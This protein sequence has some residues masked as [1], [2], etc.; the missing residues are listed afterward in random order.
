M[1]KSGWFIAMSLA[2]LFLVLIIVLLIVSVA[3]HNRGAKHV[4][5]LTEVHGVRSDEHHCPDRSQ[6]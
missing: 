6:S 3:K 5:Q 2:V 1:V 4:D